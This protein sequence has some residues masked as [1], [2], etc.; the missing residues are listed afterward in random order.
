ML[1]N[2]WIV[3]LFDS[4]SIFRVVIFPYLFKSLFHFENIE[5][6]VNFHKNGILGV[7]ITIFEDRDRDLL[8]KKFRP[9]QTFKKPLLQ[10]DSSYGPASH[11]LSRFVPPE[12]LFASVRNSDLE[13]VNQLNQ[14]KKGRVLGEWKE[15]RNI[16]KCDPVQTRRKFKPGRWVIMKTDLRVIFYHYYEN[17]FCVFQV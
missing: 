7:K 10:V 6:S 3:V 14:C 15:V 16:L 13:Y 4:C 11:L 17:D 2:K 5:K 12:V 9:P 8:I 1:E